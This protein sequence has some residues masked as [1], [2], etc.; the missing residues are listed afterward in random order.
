M[1]PTPSRCPASALSPAPQGIRTLH[2]NYA[3]AG[4]SDMNLDI[5]NEH[6]DTLFVLEEIGVCLVVGAGGGPAPGT[7]WKGVRSPPPPLLQ[8]AQPMPSHCPPDAKCQPQRH[9]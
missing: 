7:C 6:R 2:P 1:P 4:L 3:L 9:L 5:G 8:G